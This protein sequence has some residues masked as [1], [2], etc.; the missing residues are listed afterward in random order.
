MN[1]LVW[2]RGPFG[3]G[4]A[5]LDAMDPQTSME[6]KLLEQRIIQIVTL[7]DAE[8]DMPIDG[9]IVLHPCPTYEVM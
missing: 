2:K 6:W 5:S 8:R 1:F 3:V 4:V 9:L 7:I